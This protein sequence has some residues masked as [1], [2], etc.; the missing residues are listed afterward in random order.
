MKD[1]IGIARLINLGH[2]AAGK[3]LLQLMYDGPE[4]DSIQGHG[5]ASFPKIRVTSAKAIL[6]YIMIRSP[7]AQDR[8][9]ASLIHNVGMFY[10][11]SE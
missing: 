5:V 9:Y 8:R 4:C 7:R 2:T 10:G 6:Q 3:G 1:Q 11:L